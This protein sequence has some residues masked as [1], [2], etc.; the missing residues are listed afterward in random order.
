MMVYTSS[1]DNDQYSNLVSEM[2]VNAK[3]QLSNSY[4]Y[5]KIGIFYV[6]IGSE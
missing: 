5:E 1:N 3:C 4:C 6:F 2:A